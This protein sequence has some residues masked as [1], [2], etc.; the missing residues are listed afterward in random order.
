MKQWH[1]WPNILRL[2]FVALLMGLRVLG[3]DVICGGGKIEE[4]GRHGMIN[5]VT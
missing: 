4:Q 3:L 2:S 5:F 1:A